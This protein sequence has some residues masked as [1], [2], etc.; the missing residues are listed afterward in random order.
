MIDLRTINIK[1]KDTQKFLIAVAIGIVVIVLFLALLLVPK[2]SKLVYLIK[3]NA[4]FESQLRSVEKD[5]SN[6]GALEKSKEELTAEILALQK[7]FLEETQIPLFLEELSKLAEQTS[8]RLNSLK[9]PKEDVDPEAEEKTQ[10][11]KK[12]KKVPIFIEAE[13]GFHDLGRFINK[14]ESSKRFIAIS[15]INIK[16]QEDTPRLHRVRLE[17]EAIARRKAE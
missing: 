4:K 10:I 5:L 2:A 13:C 6:I 3:E 12:Y 7:T 8:V 9:L 1:D 14:L 17:V 11:E 15:D 16:A